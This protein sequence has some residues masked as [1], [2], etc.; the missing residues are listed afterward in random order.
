[1]TSS[2]RRFALVAPPHRGKTSTMQALA[3]RLR[4]AGVPLV[5]VIQPLLEGQ[6]QGYAV[7]SLHS[8]ERRLL[9]QRR[10]SGLGYD[11]STPGFQWAASEL[12]RSGPLLL[13]DEVGLLEVEGRGH[14]PALEE[15]L[16]QPHLRAAVLAVREEALPALEERLGPLEPWPLPPP[17]QLAARLDAWVAI[18]QEV[19]S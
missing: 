17:D 19:L 14:L 2:A 8:G 12:L 16:C 9:A 5:G 1:M 6:T 4:A 18:L 15:A 3:A 13:V 7:E 10:P 11:F